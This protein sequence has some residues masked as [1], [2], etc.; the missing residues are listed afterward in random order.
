VA[1]LDARIV[2]RDR[3]NREMTLQTRLDDGPGDLKFTETV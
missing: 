3:D 2:D 1:V